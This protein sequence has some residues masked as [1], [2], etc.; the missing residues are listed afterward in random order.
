MKTYSSRHHEI[1]DHSPTLILPCS[2]PSPWTNMSSLTTALAPL[3]DPFPCSLSLS[4]AFFLQPCAFCSS[5]LPLLSSITFH[6]SGSGPLPLP[7]P[8]KLRGL[9]ALPASPLQGSP[10]PVLHSLY[11]LST[12][13]PHVHLPPCLDI[14]PFC[15]LVSLDSSV[16]PHLCYCVPSLL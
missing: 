1:P 8:V 9:Q 7:T 15:F 5:A 12:P 16:L 2:G 3:P 4:S 11:C 6:L 14:C 13:T 10:R